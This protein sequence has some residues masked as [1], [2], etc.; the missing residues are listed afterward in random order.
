MYFFCER[1]PE[2]IQHL[3]WECSK[4][5]KL[6]RALKKWLKFTLQQDVSL[7][8]NEIIFN[9][10]K[11]PQKSL[12]E[13]LILVMKRYIYVT[14]CKAEQPRFTNFVALISYI[15]KIELITALSN[16]KYKYHVKKWSKYK[17]VF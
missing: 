16:D 3:F 7:E 2:T 4:V 15:E 9:E 6:W 8:F 17:N 12:I 10:Y 11:G 5:K 13:T 14:K 1:Y